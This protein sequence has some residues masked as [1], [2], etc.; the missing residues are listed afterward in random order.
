MDMRVRFSPAIKRGI[1]TGKRSAYRYPKI[2]WAE[3]YGLFACRTK[4]VA[5][6]A[7]EPEL[8]LALPVLSEGPLKPA[9]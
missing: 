4:R 2:G 9:T 3:P 8:L 1:Q 6:L 5:Q 7:A